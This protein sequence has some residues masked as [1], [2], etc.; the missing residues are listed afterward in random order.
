MA[1]EALSLEIA[2][3]RRRAAAA[4]TMPPGF[5]SMTAPPPTYTENIELP[6]S[7]LSCV[8]GDD[9]ASTT[10][11]RT[12]TSTSR[13]RPQRRLADLAG[14]VPHLGEQL[15]RRGP[16]VGDP[17]YIGLRDGAAGVDH[18]RR[19]A[20]GRSVGDGPARRGHHRRRG[21][22]R[23]AQP[24]RLARSIPSFRGPPPPMP[25]PP[26]PEPVSSTPRSTRST[27]TST[28]TNAAA[29]R[30]LSPSTSSPEL[31]QVLDEIDVEFDD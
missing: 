12:P 21:A 18:R 2:P 22:G 3:G 7:P 9:A 1:V 23:P 31:D 10:C 28:S 5:R 14:A 17:V 25:P 27:S 8:L 15:R 11:P 30:P 19:R 13:R 20:A 24:P 29:A 16:G 26:M 4:R 6:P